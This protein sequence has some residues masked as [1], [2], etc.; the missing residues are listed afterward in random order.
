MKSGGIE[1]GDALAK[2]EG[3]AEDV[4]YTYKAYVEKVLDGDTLK[5][6]FELG[7]GSRKQ[8]TIRLNHIDCP[9]LNTP[10]GQ[11]AKRFV[12]RELS[13]CEFITV[14]SVRTRKEK[15]GRYLGDVFY[16]KEGKGKLVY[17]NQLLLDKGHAVRVRN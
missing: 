12:E 17:L 15:W 16:Q 14:K 1:G 5:L 11:A 2:A 7:F 10:E 3:A 4:L 8:E 6:E 13:A 9:E